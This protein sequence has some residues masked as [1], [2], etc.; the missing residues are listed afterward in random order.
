MKITAIEKNYP[1]ASSG[2][3]TGW[4]L[5]ADSAMTNTGKPFYLPDFYGKTEVR[6]TVAVRISRLGKSVKKKFAQRYFS[7]FA[8]ALHFSLPDYGR[9][10][11]EQGLSE[12]A[13]VSF[14]RSLFVGD[15]RQID[16]EEVFELWIN[17]V[18]ASSFVMKE[19]IVPTDELM[20]RISVI[21]TVKMGDL[22]IPGFPLPVEI[23]EGDF[24]EVKGGGKTEF[25]VKVK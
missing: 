18:R 11:R 19:L 9:E 3:G 13:S 8:P 7:E 20:E 4:F 24:L 14:D 22:L 25:R 10:L 5:I 21:N 12:E 2:S 1:P 6:V 16:E 23:K 15:F 17:G